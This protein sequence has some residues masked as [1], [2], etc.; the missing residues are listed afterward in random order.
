MK[1]GGFEIVV[2]FED[3]VCVISLVP[4]VL[5][6]IEQYVGPDISSQLPD[7]NVSPAIANDDL[8]Q[9]ADDIADALDAIDTVADDGSVTGTP[10][11]AASWLM[12]RLWSRRVRAEKRSSGMPVENEAR[13]RSTASVCWSTV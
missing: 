4:D 8:V 11:L 10:S 2:L 13:L 6:L 1:E 12:A 9:I 3:N 7:Y 5:D